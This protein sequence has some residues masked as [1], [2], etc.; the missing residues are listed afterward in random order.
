MIDTRN[1]TSNR[2][3]KSLDHKNLSPLRVTKVIDNGLVV[4]VDLPERFKMHNVFH[5]WLVHPIDASPLPG[6]DD[7]AEPP[8][9]IEYDGGLAEYEIDEIL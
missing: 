7:H 8:P 2:P 9:D 5:S 1:M 6:Q 4:E 3:S